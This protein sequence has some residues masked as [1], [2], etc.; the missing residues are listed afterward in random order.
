MWDLSAQPEKHFTCFSQRCAL[1]V[2][3]KLMSFE[4]FLGILRGLGEGRGGCPWHNTVAQTKGRF[5][6]G[7]V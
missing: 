2:G 3:T 1:R 5:T 7:H 4:L 6:K